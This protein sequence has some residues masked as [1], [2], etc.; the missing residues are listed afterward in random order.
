MHKPGSKRHSSATVWKISFACVENRFTRHSHFARFLSTASLNP[1]IWSFN[2]N[3]SQHCLSHSRQQQHCLPAVLS[4]APVAAQAAD[5]SHGI[6][7]RRRRGTAA[8]SAV[9][10]RVGCRVWPST[11]GSPGLRPCGC[12]AAPDGP[13]IL[14]YS[15]RTYKVR[16]SSQN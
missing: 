4:V 14:G 12:P 16:W 9:V 8:M 3:T 6:R 2:L 1:P 15:R 11:E 13:M 10:E 5:S 7:R